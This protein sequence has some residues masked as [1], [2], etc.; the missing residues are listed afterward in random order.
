MAGGDLLPPV[1]GADALRQL[2]R[3]GEV[4]LRAAHQSP[5]QGKDE[6]LRH[7]AGRHGMTGKADQG[8]V[9]RLAHDGGFA[10]LD[11]DAVQQQ[12]AH[13]F[14]DA[15][16][17]VL[18]A[19]AAAAGEDHRVALACRLPHLPS[20]QVLVVHDD[21]V[22]DRLRAE[23]PQ[24]GREQRRV[25]IAH[26]S[27][28]RNHVGR[29]QLVPGG[30][31]A[32]AQL[33]CHG[34][35]RLSDGGQRADILRRKHAAGFQDRF[36]GIHVVAAEDEV[37]PRRAGLQDADCAVAVVLGVFDHDRAVGPL[38]DCPARG[39]VGAGVPGKAEIC[40][41]PHENLADNV[42]NRWDGVR[43]AEGVGRPAGVAVHGGAVEVR[44]IFFRG[45]I[46]RQHAAS[47][48]GIGNGLRLTQGLEFLFDQRQHFRRRFHF[49][50]GYT[51]AMILPMSR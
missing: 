50:H 49:Q 8:L 32:D 41:L 47:R 2:R 7:K 33:P 35:H 17:R 16:G 18:D 31:H 37:H 51:S 10:G 22:T 34:N 43:T 19:Y 3:D 4:L 36:A 48:L 14:Y 1:V 28:A 12:L 9:A 20:Q 13:F 21:P 11:G 6:Q 25:H 30:D 29:H 40:R 38:G 23:V 27:G 44:D 45:D 5:Q 39:N 15:A 42:Q 24:H 46:F 26:L